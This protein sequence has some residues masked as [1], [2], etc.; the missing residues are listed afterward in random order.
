MKETLNIFLPIEPVPM[1][2]ARVGRFNSVYTPQKQRAAMN[3]MKW[4]LTRLRTPLLTDALH[5]EVD[6]FISRPKSNRSKY[7]TKRP[8]LDNFIK[9]ILDCGN[10]I[11]WKDDSQIISLAASKQWANEMGPGVQI[12]I[13]AFLSD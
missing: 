3:E 6:F 2:R 4:L 7:V 9:L 1:A 10:G 11:L 8:D 12:K 5:V 13:N